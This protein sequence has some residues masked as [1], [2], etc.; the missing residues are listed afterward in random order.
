MENQTLWS[1]P[2]GDIVNVQPDPDRGDAD[3][4]IQAVWSAKGSGAERALRELLKDIIS[5]FATFN[6]QMTSQGLLQ[7]IVFIPRMGSGSTE[8]DRIRRQTNYVSWALVKRMADET[9]QDDAAERETSPQQLTPQ[10]GHR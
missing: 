2:Q 8:L 10:Q 6:E 9:R 4:A 7:M 3:E 1:S 5:S